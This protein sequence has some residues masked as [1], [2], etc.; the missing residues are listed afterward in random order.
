MKMKFLIAMFTAGLL[1][2]GAATPAAFDWQG[3][4]SRSDS[5]LRQILADGTMVKR[6]LPTTVDEQLKKQ[7]IRLDGN[8]MLAVPLRHD[9]AQTVRVLVKYPGEPA[10]AVISRHRPQDGMR[11]FEM[12]FGSQNAY[13][14]DGGKPAGQISSGKRDS[15]RAVFGK[16][17]P[18]LKPDQWYECVLRFSPGDALT[19]AVTDHATGKLLYRGMVECP[20]VTAVIPAAGDGLIG[21]GGRRNNSKNCTMLAPAGTLIGGVTVWKD[22][23]SDEELG[24]TGEGRDTVR[25][26]APVNRYVNAA[27]GDDANDGLSREK[28]FRTI[29]R[30]ADLV[31]PGNTV[32]IA[33]G[34]YFET[35]ELARGGNAEQPVTFRAD[36]KPGSVVLTAADRAIREKKVRWQPEDKALGI[37]SAPCGRAPSRVLYSGVDLYPYTTMEGLKTFLVKDGY[38][39]PEN[40]FYYDETA[41]KLYVRLH[42][43]GRYGSTDPNDHVIAVSPPFAPGSNGTHIYQKKDANFFIS[44]RKPA[45]VI[46]SGFTFETPGSAGVVTGGSNIAVRDSIFKGCRGGV[47]GFGGANAVFV[48]N[49]LYDHAYTYND[50]LDTV[51]KWGRTN[52]QKK[53]FYY[54][55]ARKGVN[56]DRDK[57]KN[58][59]TGII[60]GVA[61][62]WHVRNNV[63]DDAFE[64]MS[65]W[66]VDWAK[67]FQVYGNSFRRIVDNAV[68]TENHASDMR[69]FNNRFEDVFEPVSWQPLGG[70]PWPGPIYVYR[71]IVTCTPEFKKLADALNPGEFRPGVFKLGV[72]GR[73]WEHAA[74]GAI[75]VEQ[76]AA[77]VSKRFVMPP[78]PGFLVFNNTI[79]WPYG[80]LFTT[81]QPVYGRAARDYV[82][83]RYF[84]NIFAVD[85][86]HKRPDWKGSLFE[87][88]ANL[89][90]GNDPANPHSGII[91]G[92]GGLRADSLK[93]AGVQPDFRLASDSAARGRGILDF[94]EPDA[95][96]DLG[97]VPA[98]TE[99][100][101]VAGPGTAVDLDTLS[102]FARKVFYQPTLIRTAG[103][104]PGRWG[105]WSDAETVT[106][107][108]P[109]PAAAPR[110][111]QLVFRLTEKNAAETLLRNGS[112]SIRVIAEK[113]AG[114]LVAA[115]GKESVTFHLGSPARDL[116]QNVELSFAGGKVSAALNGTALRPEGSD[117]LT[118]PGLS[119]SWRAAIGRNPVYE[120]KLLF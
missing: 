10:G 91:S 49:C 82:N 77:R 25:N 68:E 54:F 30:A 119:G 38:P 40:G 14:L 72:A 74:M 112:F 114:R 108:L 88:Y 51:E 73:N 58:Y 116:W 100:Q 102:P 47:W 85:R 21:I 78:D 45:H 7:V 96:V 43:S 103:P 101:V 26:A 36:G 76:L 94:E 92:E 57:M 120:V 34:I 24:L 62:N 28:P 37:Y 19:L 60:G 84:N 110:G 65:C 15:I 86:M 106:L 46:L 9:D 95:S 11:G 69:I 39:A 20:D 89:E 6:P 23:L 70:K 80:N 52:I 83:F 113:G 90:V 50:V 104:E 31:N 93:Q 115:N 18:D 1:A 5:G 64:G 27:T 63:V 81:P 13:E 41:K 33:P 66:C 118:A 17:A 79:V 61:S 111:V 98:G 2:A 117:A 67:H 12:G 109:R 87:F 99:F 3:A 53:H 56:V 71:N 97:A 42:P 48:E 35:V 107:D 75:G 59:E 44:L 8:T 4:G 32:W 55:W 29:Q 105:V 22:A 16:N